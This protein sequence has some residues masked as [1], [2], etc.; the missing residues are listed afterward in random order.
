MKLLF[1][2]ALNFFS[3]RNGTALCDHIGKQ[4]RQEA[5]PVIV[6][7]APANPNTPMVLM[8][9][10][11]GGW[12]GFDQQLAAQFVNRD[13]P[14]VSLNALKYFWS[15]KTPEQATAAVAAL[16]EKYMGEWNKKEFILV[17]FSFGADVMPFVVNR[18]NGELSSKNKSVALLS[19]GT[20]TDFEIHISQMLNSKK[21][22][23]YNVVSEINKIRGK[24]VLCLFGDEEHAY[25]VKDLP[26][27]D[28][29]VIFL[30]GGHH[31][32][33]NKEDIAKLILG[34]S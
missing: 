24:Q 17:G 26:K 4:N 11:D 34:D 28:C 22:W 13:I 33:D 27:T 2:L 23:K 15:K 20:T 16:L 8:I 10:G 30:K 31:Y 14:V 19:P 32:E 29:K 25:P 12:K 21:Q 18:L 5:L 6:S 7:P 9:S 1:L 3:F